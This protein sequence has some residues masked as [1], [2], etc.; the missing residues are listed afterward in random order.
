MK[1]VDFIRICAAPCESRI[2]KTKP[3]IAHFILS[4]Q[5]R[6]H[7]NQEIIDLLRALHPGT[8]CAFYRNIISSKTWDLK[9]SV[10]ECIRRYADQLTKEELNTILQSMQD[11]LS[12]RQIKR[13]LVLP[14]HK[15]MDSY[16]KIYLYG[17]QAT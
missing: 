2:Q 8:I 16:R 6:Q 13:I 5:R 7:T 12:E 15:A 9:G 17:N 14:D 11:G 3:G 4:L 10:M 1:Y